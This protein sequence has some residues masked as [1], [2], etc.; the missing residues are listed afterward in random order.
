MDNSSLQFQLYHALSTTSLAPRI[1]LAAS[2]SLY[3][4]RCFCQ[5]RPPPSGPLAGASVYIIAGAVHAMV[6]FV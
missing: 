4:K 5:F 1:G 3:Q 6:K 2:P